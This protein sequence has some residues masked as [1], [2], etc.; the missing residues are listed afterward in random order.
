MSPLRYR[1][2]VVILVVFLILSPIPG[3]A[4]DLPATEPSK[5]SPFLTAP[6]TTSV[7]IPLG[8]IAAKATETST[9]L[10]NLATSATQS[11]QDQNIANSVPALSKR[12]DERL[13]E[14]KEALETE[15]T[16]EM[17]QTLQQEWQR[18]QVETSAWLNT[19]TQ[20]ASRLQNGLNQLGIVRQT[21]SNT[22]LS[23]E[24]SDVPAPILERIDSTLAAISEAQ[25]KLQTE[26]TAILNLQSRVAEDL[27]KCTTDAGPNRSS[28]ADS[29]R[30]DPCAERIADMESRS[31]AECDSCTAEACARSHACAL[32]RFRSIC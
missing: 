14:T 19:L 29:R 4:A 15:P 1:S 17:L 11:A 18:D 21:W 9:F 26:R 16:L 12:L 30:W 20:H 28:A 24:Q 6:P 7:A 22:R 3:T 32:V 8:D 31:V 23:A 25:A 5:P 13:R 2:C 10:T 27:S